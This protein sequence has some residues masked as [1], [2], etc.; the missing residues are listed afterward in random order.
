MA[1]PPVG[2]GH[3]QWALAEMRSARCEHHEPGSACRQRRQVRLGPGAYLADEF[4]APVA[5]PEAALA[6]PAPHATGAAAIVAITR[7]RRIKL[8]PSG[9]PSGTGP[10]VDGCCRQRS[11][12]G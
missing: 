3:V 1:G 8:S 11:V 6:V 5:Q 4:A 7:S 10:Q 2:A 12:P 9:A